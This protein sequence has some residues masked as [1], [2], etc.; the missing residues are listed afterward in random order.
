VSG[1]KKRTLPEKNA[2]DVAMRLKELGARKGFSKKIIIGYGLSPINPIKCGRQIC[3]PRYSYGPAVREFW[4]LHFV[5]SGK[6]ILLNQNGSHTVKKN[7]V[8]VIRP[9]EEATYTADVDDPW[10]YVW[11]GFSSTKRLPAILETQDVFFAPYLKPFFE[12][13]HEGIGGEGGN[14]FGAYEHYLCGVI[15]Q[16]IGMLMHHSRKDIGITDAYI[17]PAISMMNDYYSY[18]ITVSDIAAQ[19][20]ISKGYFSEIFKR[21]T[22]ISPKKYL[23]DIR[24]KHAAERLKRGETVTDVAMLMGYP[25]VFAFSRAFKQHYQCSPTEYIKKRRER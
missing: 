5:I 2:E 8:F 1:D 6:G 21:E 22:G 20:H 3:P 12:S 10:E 19:L 18:R 25:D 13:A 23:N 15:W 17:R 11:I 7:E 4:L 9:H 14:T 16:I 24:M